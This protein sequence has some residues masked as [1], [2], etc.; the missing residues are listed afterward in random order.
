[1]E[2]TDKKLFIYMEIYSLYIFKK[3]QENT[4]QITYNACDPN[5]KKERRRER[6]R[7]R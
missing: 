4:L 3:K 2:H 1:M 6:N 7:D 5:W